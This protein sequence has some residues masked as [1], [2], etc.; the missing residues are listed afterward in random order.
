M[1]DMRGYVRANWM[2]WADQYK[3]LTALTIPGTHDTCT[4]TFGPGD[5]SRCQEMTLQDQLLQGI[6]FI[7]IRLVTDGS[8]FQIKHGSGNT[9]LMFKA[10]VLDVCKEF[11]Q[12]H[13]SETIVMSL[14]NEADLDSMTAQQVAASNAALAKTLTPFLNDPCFYRQPNQPW[15]ND[16]SVPQLKDARGKI[17]PFR[18]FDAPALGIDA[19]TGWPDDEQT[20]TPTTGKVPM[21]IQDTYGYATVG[22]I[23]TKW[24]KVEDFLLRAAGDPNISS[25]GIWWITFSSGSS[26]GAYPD[27]FAAVINPRLQLWLETNRT[28]PSRL[29]TV[30]M[31]F[32]NPREIDLLIARNL[33]NVDLPGRVRENVDYHVRL[34][35][36]DAGDTPAFI[37]DAH[38]DAGNRWNYAQVH[39]G[40]PTG[41][42]YHTLH[43]VTV[44]G[45]SPGMAIHEG[46]V[47]LVQSSQFTNDNYVYL[48]A[49]GGGVDVNC[50]Y[51]AVA[52]DDVHWIVERSPDETAPTTEIMEG[53]PIRLRSASVTINSGHTPC[54]LAAQ[55]DDYLCA[56]SDKDSDYDAAKTYPKPFDWV[57][58][59]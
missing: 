40:Q 35:C 5:M 21:M 34:A 2:A 28:S 18:R 38:F 13:P 39:P 36:R 52:G 31:D 58:A 51:D 19:Y 15:M 44:A 16:L 27:A 30:V 8:D 47:V 14:K 9:G 54:Y 43:K 3:P 24:S 55:T 1:G 4:S 29:G 46:D 25:A 59:R 6:R 53:E 42:P 11:L 22:D 57:F 48:S 49:N 56:E 20:K 33:L 10:D 37:G 7:D 50:R 26:A 23:G 32:P 41:G 45:E 12:D 17:V